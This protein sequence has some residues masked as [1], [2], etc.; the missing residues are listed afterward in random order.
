[1]R[2][3]SLDQLRYE[4]R[5]V[6]LERDLATPDAHL[7]F[8]VFRQQPAQLGHGFRRNDDVR[9]VTLRKF[10]LDVDHRESPAI[11][12]NEGELVFLETEEQP[13]QDVARLVGRDRV[14]SFP[15]SIA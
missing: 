5:I 6:E 10:Q 8:A 2:I 7:Y 9:L 3:I 14:G 12:R 4:Q 1:V 13:V 15:Q 11:S